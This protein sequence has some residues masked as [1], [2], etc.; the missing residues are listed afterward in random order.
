LPYSGNIYKELVSFKSMDEEKFVRDI[1]EEL[2]EKIKQEKEEFEKITHEGKEKIAF[3]SLVTELMI[4]YWLTPILYKQ[5]FHIIE[6]E[7]TYSFEKKRKGKGGRK[8]CDIYA[9]KDNME[10]WIELKYLL[11]NTGWTKRELEDD[12]EKLSKEEGIGIFLVICENQPNCK[13]MKLMKEIGLNTISA[14][15]G[16]YSTY[17]KI[18]K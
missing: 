9:K 15:I 16:C 5:G 6:S 14:E 10:L 13:A 11:S 7:K 18:I 8:A 1:S 12:I 2:L 17:Y 4:K 3:Y